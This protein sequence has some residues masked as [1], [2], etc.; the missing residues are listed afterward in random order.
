MERRYLLFRAGG[1]GYA[2]ALKEVIEVRETV[3]VYPLPRVPGYLTGVVNSHG[4]L[5][6]L[7]DFALFMGGQRACDEGKV[8]VLDEKLAAL[9]LRVDEV[10]AIVPQDA[11]GELT[12]GEARYELGRL[13]TEFGTVRLVHVEALVEA[14]E[15]HLAG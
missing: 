8:L 13:E 4:N 11:V 2:L 7:L 15:E 12:P 9:A 5:T 14:V 1:V 3:A 10:M 6:T